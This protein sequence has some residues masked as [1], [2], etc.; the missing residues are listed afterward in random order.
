VRAP[1]AYRDNSGRLP[2]H[3]SLVHD[4]TLPARIMFR[5]P[6]QRCAFIDTDARRSVGS[7]DMLIFSTRAACVNRNAT[8]KRCRGPPRTVLDK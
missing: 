1:R 5:E 2:L 3:D 8:R 7:L 4:I 6:R